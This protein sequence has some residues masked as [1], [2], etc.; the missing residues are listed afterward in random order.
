[1]VAVAQSKMACFA[2]P[3]LV[4]LDSCGPNIIVYSGGDCDGE[5]VDGKTADAVEKVI[6]EHV[7]GGFG[8]VWRDGVLVNTLHSLSILVTPPLQID[9]GDRKSVV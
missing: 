7:G 6:A 2:V 5:R 8:L 3:P 9:L 1:M 4:I